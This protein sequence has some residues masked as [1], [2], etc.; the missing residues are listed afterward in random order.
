[1]KTDNLRNMKIDTGTPKDW[2]TGK[3]LSGEAKEGADFHSKNETV[4]YVADNP[5][6]GGPKGGRDARL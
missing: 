2:K 5:P 6:T 3:Q 1:M 4:Q